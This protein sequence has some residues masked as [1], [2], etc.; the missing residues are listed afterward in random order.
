VHARSRPLAPADFGTGE[1]QSV[2]QSREQE[3]N[4]GNSLCGSDVTTCLGQFRALSSFLPVLGS[5][6]WRCTLQIQPD[7]SS[8]LICGTFHDPR[9]L[10]EVWASIFDISSPT[11]MLPDIHT[12][13]HAYCDRLLRT[14]CRGESNNSLGTQTYPYLTKFVR[15]SDPL[16]S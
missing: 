8:T 7:S 2:S 6:F 14:P 16:P 10:D 4:A 3:P 15:M 5:C 13:K 9:K 11:D 12:D 1:S